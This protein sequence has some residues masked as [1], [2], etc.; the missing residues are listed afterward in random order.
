MT[1]ASVVIAPARLKTPEIG[2]ARFDVSL[3]SN[4]SPTDALAIAADPAYTAKAAD[5]HRKAL[6]IPSDHAEGRGVVPYRGNKR[7]IHEHGRL[8]DGVPG[9]SNLFPRTFGIPLFRS[10]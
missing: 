1:A 5:S 3:A 2:S 4:H 8:D 7:R 6:A 10:K 9:I